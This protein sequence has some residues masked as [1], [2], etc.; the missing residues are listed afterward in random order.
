M[1]IRIL[2]CVFLT[3]SRITFTQ[4]VQLEWAARYN[5]SGNDWDAALAIAVDDSGNVC[6]TGGSLGTGTDRDY[7]TIK[8]TRSGDSSWVRRFNGHENGFD[9]AR[10]I[11]VDDSGNVYVTGTS[12]AATIKYDKFGN[13]LWLRRFGQFSAGY[14]LLLNSTNNVVIAGESGFDFMTLKYDI[15]GSL[16]WSA[17]FNG[18]A[19]DNDRVN[20]MVPDC[21][22]NIIVTGQ[23]WGIGTQWDYLTIK[24]SPD[25]DTLWVRRYNGPAPPIEVSTDIG[26]GIAADDSG[27]AYVTGWSDGVSGVPQCLTIKYSP[28]GN[29]LWER[30]FPSGGSIGYVGYD[31]L[32]DSSGSIYV[33][34]RANGFEDKLLKYDRV[35][36]LVWSA[37]YPANHTFATNP[38]RLARDRFGNIYITSSDFVDPHT[39]YVVLKYDP[40]GNQRWEFRYRPPGNASFTT[41]NAYALA[42]DSLLYVYV[43]GESYVAGT[44]TSYDY[45]TLKIS[46]DPTSVQPTSDLIPNR[47]QLLQNYPNPFNAS[48]KIEFTLPQKSFV[49]L[50]VFNILG[51]EV[52]TLLSEELP[53]G[54]HAASWEPFDS[55]SGV[56]IC[57]LQTVRE[58]ITI[59][60]VLIK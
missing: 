28:D 56:Y 14:R 11:A 27:N 23:S 31:I 29:T 34:V 18:Q 3:S 26:F 13:E 24:Y 46:Q 38:P 44:G 10:D 1:K 47:I 60:L 37:A 4:Q 41:N 36:N 16:L 42:V 59:K 57:R 20:D 6:V 30:R 49:L 39:Y 35:G 22:G 52:A 21:Q 50:K 55:P 2:L 32:N 43:T 19:N 45:L 7:A 15:G 5:G 8:Y 54:T 48:T 9:V 12:V 40:N 17:T 58:F 51:Q 33:A 25:G 53:I